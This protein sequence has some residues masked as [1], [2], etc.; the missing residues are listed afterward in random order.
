MAQ[1]ETG[2]SDVLSGPAA[3]STLTVPP[4][5]ANAV[6]SELQTT[7]EQSVAIEI[8][9]A[10]IADDESFTTALTDIINAAYGE[11]EAGIFKPGYSRT[12]PSD[13]ATQLRAGSLAVATKS[14]P[15]SDN[16]GGLTSGRIPLGCISIRKLNK[17][18]AE[19]GMFA[20]AMSQR[21]TGIGRDLIAWAE[22]WCRDELGGPGVAV[23]QLELLVP[24]HFEH[25]FK[26]RIGAWY[27]RLGYQIVG[28][29]DFALDY[30]HLAPLLAGPTE[31]RVLEKTLV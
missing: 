15:V 30:P 29:R 1:G 25:A 7:N 24:T 16:T 14:S 6:P 18:R 4:T 31:Y 19:L 8:P 12:S 17:T 5:L 22:R 28:R 10:S 26:V 13:V 20:V 21:G 9:P 27:A 11:A 23:A 3:I 2:S